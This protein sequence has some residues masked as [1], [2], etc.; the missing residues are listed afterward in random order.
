MDILF[1]IK[2]KKWTL[3]LAQAGDV[4]LIMF[5]ELCIAQLFKKTR[6]IYMDEC[7]LQDDEELRETLTHEL[8][9]AYIMTYAISARQFRDEEFICEFMAVYGADIIELTKHLIAQLK[10]N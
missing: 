10:N 8:V 3:K 1:N 6:T 2:R 4:N 5:G 9:H 7:L